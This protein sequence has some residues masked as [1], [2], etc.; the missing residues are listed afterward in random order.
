MHEVFTGEY[1]QTLC[2][3]A[4][5]LPAEL[6]TMLVVHSRIIFKCF[7]AIRNYALTSARDRVWFDCVCHNDR[8]VV[9][10][11]LSGLDGHQ[12]MGLIISHPTLIDTHTHTHSQ[13]FPPL[14]LVR[15]NCCGVAAWAVCLPRAERAVS[16]LSPR[17]KD[18]VGLSF[19]VLEQ[20]CYILANVQSLR[21]FQWIR[22]IDR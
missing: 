3:I 6:A 1:E 16:W 8:L 18:W 4:L 21:Q 10:L 14:Y 13:L 12:C 7:F 17:D 11:P 22:L 20:Q 2:S 9:S 19:I 15:P 5:W